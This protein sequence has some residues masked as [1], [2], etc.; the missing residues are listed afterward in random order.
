MAVERQA[1]KSQAPKSQAPKCQVEAL[2]KRFGTRTAV[3]NVSFDVAEG[4]FVVLLGPSGCGKT[5][6]L[7][8][9]AGLA[10]P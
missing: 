8:L 1:P 6:T 3:D 2:T 5:T 9:I 4:E 10:S 7:R